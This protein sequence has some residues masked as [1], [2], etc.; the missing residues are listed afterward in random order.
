MEKPINYKIVKSTGGEPKKIDLEL[1]LNNKVWV[2]SG[3]SFLTL[4]KDYKVTCTLNGNLFEISIINHNSKE[5][6]KSG[7][8]IRDFIYIFEEKRKNNKLVGLPKIVI[9]DENDEKWLSKKEIDKIGCWLTF[10]AEGKEGNISYDTNGNIKSSEKSLFSRVPHCPTNTSGVTIGRGFDLKERDK[11]DVEVIFKK[12]NE[13]YGCKPINKELMNWLV[14]GCR[15]VGVNATKYINKISSDVSPKNRHISRK[16]QYFLFKEILNMKGG[17]KAE[18]LRLATTKTIKI[19]DDE[20][21]KKLPNWVKDILIDLRYRGDNDGNSR[22][23]FMP[24][25]KKGV[26]TNNYK[27][28]KEL[29]NDSNYWMGKRGVPKDRFDRRKNYANANCK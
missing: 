2:E 1:A 23:V 14:G 9:D 17:F 12:L 18:A 16:Q 29:M 10:D 15:K 20:Y 26:E 25:I 11:G 4:I 24:L 21:N 8:N 3:G 28:F 27:K 22:A 19:T 6:Y 5:V 13:V 7:E